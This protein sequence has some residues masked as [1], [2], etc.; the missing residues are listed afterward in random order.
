[1]LSTP[2]RISEGIIFSF[3]LPLVLLLLPSFSQ[4]I[5][6]PESYIGGNDGMVLI[7]LSGIG[8]VIVA[9]DLATFF[10][11]FVVLQ[12]AVVTIEEEVGSFQD[13]F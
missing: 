12:L 7:P 1:M 10:L 9:K 2:L 13:C 11:D 6:L 5:L 8:Q 4:V 3:P